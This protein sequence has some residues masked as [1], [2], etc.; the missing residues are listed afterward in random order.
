MVDFGLVQDIERQVE[1]AGGLKEAFEKGIY[2]LDKKGQPH[3]NRIRHIRVWAN[4]SEPLKIK[5]QTNL[6]KAEYKQ[7][8]YAGNGE[9]IA[10]GLYENDKKQRGFQLRNCLLYTSRCV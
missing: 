2:L 6:S 5:K 10:Y 3:G 1:E 4:V 9:N 8:Y 7:H